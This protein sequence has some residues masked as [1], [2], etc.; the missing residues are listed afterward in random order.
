MHNQIT[1]FN[2]LDTM[3]GKKYNETDE[4]LLRINYGFPW[5]ECQAIAAAYGKKRAIDIFGN[6]DKKLM[7][8]FKKYHKENP[9]IYREFKR[10]A[11]E[12]KKVRNKSSA[13]LIVNRIRWDFDIKSNS[14]EVWKI[15]NDYIAVYARMLIYNNPEFEGFFTLKAMKPSG[16]VLSNEEKYNEPEMNTL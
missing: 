16:R 12:M 4:K 6:I 7:E 8:K 10:Y 1:G 13:W 11:L 5:N 14:D 15:S 3:K 2:F 9:H